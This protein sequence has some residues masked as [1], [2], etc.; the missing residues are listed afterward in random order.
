MKIIKNGLKYILLISLAI[1]FLGPL[2]YVIYTSL[3]PF[4]YVNKIAPLD[5]ISLDNF[6]YLF[7]NYPIT[8][9]YKNTIIVTL[10]TLFGN[11]S[12][13]LMAGFALAKLKFKGRKFIFNVIMATLMIPFQLLITPLY[14]MVAG[15]DWHNTIMGLTIPFLVN[16]LSIFMARQFYLSFP[17]ELLEAARV[18]GIG[19][20]KSFFKVVLPLSGT[21]IITL[22]IFNFTSTWNSYLVPATFI[23]STE[24]FT[25]TVGLNTIKDA[26]FIRPNLTMAGIILLSVPVLTVFAFLQKY[27]IQG[28]ATSGSKEA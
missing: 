7:E 9:W 27:F 2:V 3:V 11:I 10:I 18:D 4:E 14:I 26:N 24:N 28:I 21:L 8:A 1:L 19:Y 23:S 13:S 12:T 6:I 25:L 20:I 22:I 5:K 15:L 16:S 17:D